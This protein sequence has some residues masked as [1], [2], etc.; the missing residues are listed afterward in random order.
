MKQ[1]KKLSTLLFL[2]ICS[3]GVFSQTQLEMNKAASDQYLTF[4]QELKKVC[5]KILT[6][7]SNDSVFIEKFK[8]AQQT[9]IKYRDAEVEMKF[10]SEDKRVYGSMFPM[11]RSGILTN[12]TKERIDH[13]NQW[14]KPTQDGEGCTG[15]MKYRELVK[16]DGSSE[17]I[18]TNP[19]K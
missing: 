10:P 15:S 19:K 18:D 14:L 1:F 7:Y 11:C 2:M 4:D 12:M 3:L 13:L 9:W 8:V 17:I 6:A 5:D 16:E